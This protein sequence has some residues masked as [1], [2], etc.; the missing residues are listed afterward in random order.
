MLL[1]KAKHSKQELPVGKTGKKVK[2]EE[3]ETSWKW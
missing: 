2:V 1:Q 3:E